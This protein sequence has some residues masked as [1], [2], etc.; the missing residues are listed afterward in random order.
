[1]G[2]IVSKKDFREWVKEYA[3]KLV[4][5][6]GEKDTERAAFLKKKLPL[7]VQEILG[8][9]KEIRFYASKDDYLDL[10][11]IVVF[12]E[13]PGTK[14]GEEKEGTACHIMVIKDAVEEKLLN[15]FII[16]PTAFG[17]LPFYPMT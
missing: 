11:G 17:L 15:L 9:F 16:D 7:F 4:K 6:V 2:R 12:L 8:K 13:Q 10:E 14:D 5:K 3:A 1:M